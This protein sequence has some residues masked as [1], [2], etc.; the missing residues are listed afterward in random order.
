MCNIHD[1]N[2]ICVLTVVDFSEGSFFFQFKWTSLFGWSGRF[3]AFLNLNILIFLHL[4]YVIVGIGMVCI[5]DLYCKEEKKQT[6]AFQMWQRAKR[7][8]FCATP[9]GCDLIVYSDTTDPTEHLGCIIYVSAFF[10]LSVKLVTNLVFL[11]FFLYILNIMI[12][13]LMLSAKICM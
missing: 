7:T 11:L 1:F 2:W 8:S 4:V 5:L 3:S 6:N 12:T 9:T 13:S 10:G